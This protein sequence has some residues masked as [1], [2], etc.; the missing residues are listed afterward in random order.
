[1]A[2]TVIRQATESDLHGIG[3]LWLKLVQYH[4]ALDDMM[5]VATEDGSALYQNRVRAQFA[6]PEVRT[7]VADL[8]GRLIGFVLGAMVDLRAEMFIREKTGHVA[9]IFVEEGHRECGVGRRLIDELADWFR[10]C[11]AQRIEW[12]VASQNIAG[13]AFWEAMGGREVMVR[14]GLDL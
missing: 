2:D 4:N 11:G 7:L 5:P 14:M 1:M 10:Q 8:D 3:Q 6:S 9:D 13:R 12:S